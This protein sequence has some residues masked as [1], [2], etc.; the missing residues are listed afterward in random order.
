MGMEAI[1]E[2]ALSE[3]LIEEWEKILAQASRP[4]PFLTPAWFA[5][6]GKHFGR[7]LDPRFIFFR[8]SDGRFIGLGAFAGIG[9][10]GGPKGLHLLGSP[11]VCDYRDMI[12]SS[13]QE[14]EVFE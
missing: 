9:G 8:G 7:S 2:N 6:W 10:T 4:N 11:D 14:S 1:I 13:G 3:A 5:V 12:I